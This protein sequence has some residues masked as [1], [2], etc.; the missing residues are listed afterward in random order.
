MTARRQPARNTDQGPGSRDHGRPI[1]GFTCPAHQFCPPAHKAQ[2]ISDSL[3]EEAQQ[4]FRGSNLMVDVLILR[5]PI[6][7]LPR[8]AALTQD[9]LPDGAPNPRSGLARL[10]DFS[11]ITELKV[12]AT[13]M[14]GLDQGEVLQDFRKLSYILAAAAKQYGDPLP[15][16][17]VGVLD[18]HP[19][20]RFDFNLLKERLEQA[21]VRP[22]VRLLH[23]TR[24][25]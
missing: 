16:A 7:N 22:D 3:G 25:R 21:G 9:E 5:E 20:R 6:V 4:H 17:Y 23:L 1:G 19:T 11:V 12:S 18:N 15:A 8:R 24:Y 10:Q 13:Q 14:G 2:L